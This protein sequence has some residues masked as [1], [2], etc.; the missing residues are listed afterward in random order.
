MLLIKA[1]APAPTAA[2]EKVDGGGL[3][4]QIISAATNKLNTTSSVLT[5]SQKNFQESS[6]SYTKV[7][8]ALGAIQGDIS[9]MK[10]DKVELVSMALK[11]SEGFIDPD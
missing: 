5:S 7:M 10:A 8:T 6:E 9:K 11:H 4:A 1:K 2:Y 3:R